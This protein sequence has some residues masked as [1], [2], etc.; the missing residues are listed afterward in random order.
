[1]MMKIMWHFLGEENVSADSLGKKVK[2]PFLWLNYFLLKT[3]VF[4][5]TM[6]TWEL[7]KFC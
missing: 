3:K 1:M 6:L 4:V 5:N 7:L 2:T